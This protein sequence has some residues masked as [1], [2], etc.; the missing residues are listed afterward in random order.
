MAWVTCSRR[1]IWERRRPASASAL[2]ASARVSASDCERA[3][4]SRGESVAGPGGRGRHMQAQRTGLPARMHH[5][6]R[7]MPCSPWLARR[8]ASSACPAPRQPPRTTAPTS[9]TTAAWGGLPGRPKSR[10]L[11][12]SHWPRARL[13]Q[14]IRTPGRRQDASPNAQSQGPPPHSHLGLELLQLRLAQGR[15]AR[16]LLAKLHVGWGHGRRC[17]HHPVPGPQMHPLGR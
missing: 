10:G 13:A 12:G 4:G 1:S 9:R 17:D 2:A 16:G 8:R 14:G 6:A 3:G 7:S 11:G 15:T 5:A